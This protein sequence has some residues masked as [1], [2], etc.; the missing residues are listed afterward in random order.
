MVGVRYIGVAWP[1]SMLARTYNVIVIRVVHDDEAK[2]DMFHYF[3]A[4]QRLRNRSV[5]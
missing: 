3:A 1:E 2:D 5:I 4:N